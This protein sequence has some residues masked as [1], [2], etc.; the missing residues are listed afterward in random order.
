MDGKVISFPYL[1]NSRN[2]EQACV[3]CIIFWSTT[4]VQVKI[5]GAVVSGWLLVTAALIT[6]LKLD[7]QE[8]VVR[9]LN[10]SKH[11]GAGHQ[12]TFTY[13]L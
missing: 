9:V 4:F 8:F 2:N 13:L 7:I 12:S 1:S 6:Q 11:C 5:Q 3:L 10:I